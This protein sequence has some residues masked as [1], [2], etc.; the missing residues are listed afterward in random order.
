MRIMR[1]Q[2]FRYSKK[3]NNTAGFIKKIKMIT[4]LRIKMKVSGGFGDV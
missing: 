2:W 1:E 4:Y 3:C